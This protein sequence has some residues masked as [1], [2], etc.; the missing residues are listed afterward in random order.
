MDWT[1]EKEDL[2]GILYFQQEQFSCRVVPLPHCQLKVFLP[3]CSQVIGLP[4]WQPDDRVSSNKSLTAPMNGTV[5]AVNVIAGQSVD[6]GFL[7]LTMEAMKM[8]YSIKA[9]KKG[10]IDSVYFKT[11]DQVKSGIT[12]LAFQEDANATA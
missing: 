4:G 7:L 12:L 5:T 3:D 8:E 2:S 6:T 1:S 9:H 10:V 11:G